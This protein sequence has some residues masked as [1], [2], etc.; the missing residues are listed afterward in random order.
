MD[1]LYGAFPKLATGGAIGDALFF[2]CSGFTLFLGKPSSFGNW[3]KRRVNRIYPTLF[4]WYIV[5]SLLM[6]EQYGMWTIITSGG[7]WFVSCIMLYYIAI[8]FVKRFWINYLKIVFAL[9]CALV[10]SW[11]LTMDSTTIFMYKGTYLKW[12]FFFLF[13]LIGAMLGSSTPSLKFRLLTDSIKL[14]CS[15]LVF[16]LI[17]I[18]GEMRPVLAHFQILSLIPLFSV[19]FYFYKVCNTEWVLKI[20]N[21][22]PVRRAVFFVSMLCLEVY[23]VQPTLL[24]YGAFLP[25]PLGIP[26]M[27]AVI[28]AS[29][30]LLKILSNLFSQTF[31]DSDYDWKKLFR[32]A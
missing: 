23:L 17:Q 6:D 29:A 1:M 18:G 5:S 30:Y 13:M 4:S 16:Y 14:F 8:W 28:I 10:V 2:F 25:F 26:V 7:G 20:Y 11:Y 32:V 27:F 15:V 24:Q 3:Y 31:N 12:L 19:V 22:T 9:I 21:M